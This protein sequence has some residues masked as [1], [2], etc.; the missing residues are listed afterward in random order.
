MEG[1]G[2]GGR[3]GGVGIPFRSKP[4]T[5][6]LRLWSV[7]PH[8]CF[9]TPGLVLIL[10]A[11]LS[12]ARILFWVVSTPCTIMYHILIPFPPSCLYLTVFYLASR[13]YIHCCRKAP[14]IIIWPGP[15]GPGARSV[16]AGRPSGRETRAFRVTV[17]APTGGL[18]QPCHAAGSESGAA[19]H[20]DDDGGPGPARC[21]AAGPLPSGRP[22]C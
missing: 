21:R 19:D 8:L 16:A 2:G 10:P 22:G 12:H 14:L 9:C 1:R 7:T 11:L 3:K 17:P 6:F 5:A 13:Q 18:A 20:R 4:C 15:A